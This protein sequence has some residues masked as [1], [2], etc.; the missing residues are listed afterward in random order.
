MSS[1]RRGTIKQV[2]ITSPMRR[3]VIDWLVEVQAYYELHPSTL[4]LAVC[5]FDRYLTNKQA[6]RTS[7]QLIGV[8]CMMMAS[9]MEDVRCMTSNATLVLT[10]NTA[11]RYIKPAGLT[12]L[13]AAELHCC[14]P[15]RS[16]L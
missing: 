15:C 14:Q 8:V 11:F 16:H 6:S 9:K 7:L 4:F 3:I 13:S 5:Y 1:N 12:A 2:H 10:E